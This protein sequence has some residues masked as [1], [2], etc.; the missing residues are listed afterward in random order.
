MFHK[1]KGG[2]KKKLKQINKQKDNSVDSSQLAQVLFSKEKKQKYGFDTKEK[3]YTSLAQ[4][5]QTLNFREPY[6]VNWKYITS[7]DTD[8]V[9]VSNAKDYVFKND[10]GIKQITQGDNLILRGGADGV[11]NSVY[12]YQLNKKDSTET[13]VGKLNIISFIQKIKKLALVSVNGFDPPR[14][15]E[16]E[17]NRIYKQAG[18]D[19][20]ITGKYAINVKYDD[21]YFNHGGSSAMACYNKDQKLLINTLKEITNIDK[22]TYYLFFIKEV[23]DKGRASSPVE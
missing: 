18:V 9:L 17:L 20:T 13:V 21:G 1:T 4:Q 8:K 5:Y 12:A 22:D 10:L 15:I 7:F 6:N 3:I 23:K 19:W 2:T 11:E 14:G 16:K